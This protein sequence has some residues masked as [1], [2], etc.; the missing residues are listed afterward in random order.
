MY[1]S[2]AYGGWSVGVAGG[3]S[4]PREKA[5]SDFFAHVCGR[6]QSFDDVVINVSQPVATGADPF[7]KS[8]LDVDAWVARGF[9]RQ[10]T[11]EYLKTIG[12]QLSSPNTV[13]DIRFPTGGKF[14]SSLN[15]AVHK[16]LSSFINQTASP[17]QDDRLGV[18]REIEKTW[19]EL[20]DD[21]E[22]NRLAGALTLKDLYQKSFNTYVTPTDDS[23]ALSVGSI[24]GILLGFSLVIGFAV[25]VIVYVVSL[26][27]LKDERRLALQR[28]ASLVEMDDCDSCSFVVEE[29]RD[30]KAE[31]AKLMRTESNYVVL[32]RSVCFVC[33]MFLGGLVVAVLIEEDMFSVEA[34]AHIVIVL[35]VVLVVS[36]YLYD[37]A[38]RRR[39]DLVVENAAQANAIVSK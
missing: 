25:G 35:I 6:E 37:R 26:R 32:W 3:L 4:K 8:Q 2:A 13:L 21:Y 10:A 15:E 17:T 24:V 5:M 27:R 30:E 1:L 28:M 19:N 31:I 36:F 9:G 22:E 39:T 23:R 29:T 38:V 20:V 14:T 7:R 18:A 16:Y 12:D 11:E 33:L 34:F